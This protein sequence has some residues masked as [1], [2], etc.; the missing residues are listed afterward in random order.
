MRKK[1][2]QAQISKL[3]SKSQQTVNITAESGKTSFPSESL[4]AILLIVIVSFAVY[5]NTLKNGFV[6]DDEFTIVNNT[7]IK[8]LYNLPKLFQKDYFTLS[9]E[10]TYRPVVTLTYL[11]DYALYGLQPW[12]YHLT[13]VLL[14]VINGVLLYIFLSLITEPSITN[15][16]S[17]SIS[18]RLF[19]NAPLLISLLFV[20]NPVLTEAVNGISYR[21]DLLVFLFSIAALTLYVVLR[22]RHEVITQN[23]TIFFIL[24]CWLYFLALLSKEMALT[25]PLIVICYGWV[26]SKEKI[27]IKSLLF[28]RYNI[29]Y[30][31]VTLVY[32]YLRFYY[33]RNPA[34]GEVPPWQLTERL[35]TIP[36]LVITYIKLI[37]FPISLSADYVIEPIKSLFSMPFIYCTALTGLTIAAAWKSRNRIITFGIMFFII[38]LIPVYNIIPIGNPLA[39]RYLYMPLL[40]LTIVAGLIFHQIVVSKYK[41]LS[42]K[43]ALLFIITIYSVTVVER[44]S[45]WK[46]SYSLWSD[47]VQKM[48]NS[49]RAHTSLGIV[50]YDKGWVDKAIEQ[51]QI[52]ISLK[53]GYSLAHNNLGVAY[54]AQNKLNEAIAEYKEALILDPDNSDAHFNL[55]TVF[56]KQDR[57]DA[58]LNEYKNAIK[59]RPYEPD[60]HYSLGSLY[61]DQG[62]LEEAMK[63][64]QMALIQKSDYPD[65][66]FKLG[67]IY[68]MQRNL[69]RAVQHYRHAIDLR[70]DNQMYYNNLGIVLAEMGD[71]DAAIRALQAALKIKPNYPDSH[72][73]L[74]IALYKYG[75]IDEAV[76]QFQTALG[77]NVNLMPAHYYLGLI[78][79]QKGQIDMARMEFETV[80]K[81]KPDFIQAQQALKSL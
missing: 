69:D 71:F 67:I 7:L 25:F 6:Y 36:W 40:G 44:N 78:Y 26:F 46:N 4:T 75:Q 12:G 45:V 11:L 43:A 15:N 3:E 63:E 16:K 18:E 51:H 55:G 37:V 10:G 52:A 50:Y 5:G 1:R 48:P 35:S 65:A 76:H 57:A 68:Y 66:H 56:Q 9:G 23:T 2:K 34:N 62:K 61:L 49:S 54:F 73:N 80:L 70:P 29:G 77:I 74:G 20:T 42:I 8:S 79:K 14:H 30:L 19:S 64:L 58:A 60:V 13:N 31:V 59:L 28:N 32:I 39:E 38:A 27:K 33:F 81:L 17:S 41:S 47:T 24:S 53:P 22:T 72:I 21:E